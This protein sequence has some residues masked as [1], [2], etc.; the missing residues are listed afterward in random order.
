MFIV[1]V[2][3]D[4]NIKYEYPLASHGN[5]FFKKKYP[6][7]YKKGV[8]YNPIRTVNN[9]LETIDY[10]NKSDIDNK[11]MNHNKKT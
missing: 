1:A 8:K 10:E 9:A 5:K 6:D 11:S 2:R 3:N 4:I 7:L